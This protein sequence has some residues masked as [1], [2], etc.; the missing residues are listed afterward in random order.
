MMLMPCLLFDGR[1]AEALAFYSSLLPNAK[2]TDEMRGQGSALIAA[3]L[4]FQGGS[5]LVLNGPSSEPSVGVSLFLEC[6][7]Q[8]EVDRLWDR[9]S[10][11]GKPIQCGWI[12]DRFG[13]TWQIVPQGLR[14]LLGD[15]DPARAQRAMQAMMAMKKLD[16]NEIARAANRA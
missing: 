2:V 10:E 15:P 12:T 3:T 14:D 6:E 1:A 13:V 4:A 9:L 5:M 11:G 8:A 16:I 7:K